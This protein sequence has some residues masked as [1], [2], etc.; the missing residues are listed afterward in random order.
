ML[1]IGHAAEH[2]GAPLAVEHLASFLWRRTGADARPAHDAKAQV[3]KHASH[4]VEP[5]A[6]V[7]ALR[8][9]GR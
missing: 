4:G 8:T 5:I 3:S 6:A 2:E 9:E 1:N 7:D